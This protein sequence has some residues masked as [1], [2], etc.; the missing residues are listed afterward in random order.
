MLIL[1][2]QNIHLFIEDANVIIYHPQKKIENN[3]QYYYCPDSYEFAYAIHK[4]PK[5]TCHRPLAYLKM[6]V[7]TE[8]IYI[9][10]FNEM[11]NPLDVINN[12]FDTIQKI[13]GVNSLLMKR[14]KN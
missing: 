11:Q 5:I 12:F 10:T 3:Q 8:K 4:I 1:E 9:K 14:K 2:P 7:Y 13:E 6:F